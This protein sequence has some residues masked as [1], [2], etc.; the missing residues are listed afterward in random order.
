LPALC[1]TITGKVVGIADGDIITVLDDGNKQHT[2]HLY[3][4]DCPEKSHIRAGRKEAYNGSH[5]SEGG[6]GYKP[7]EPQNQ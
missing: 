7:G 5:G 4:I 6:N 3:G 1:Q 2:I